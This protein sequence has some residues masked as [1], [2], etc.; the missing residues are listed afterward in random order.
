[1]S[2]VSSITNAF[3]GF[4]VSGTV[5]NVGGFIG[6]C[7]TVISSDAPAFVRSTPK[8]AALFAVVNY[9][10]VKISEE[11]ATTISKKVPA[12][13][14]RHS[15]AHKFATVAFKATEVA[16]V[17]AANSAFASALQ[18]TASRTQ[19]AVLSASVLALRSISSTVLAK[20]EDYKNASQQQA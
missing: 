19:L 1:M 11:I 2:F 18:L 13:V 9:G 10:V 15:I 3:S 8:T 20:Y 6:R 12:S 17:Y 14:K 16:V 4:S 7:W 5:S